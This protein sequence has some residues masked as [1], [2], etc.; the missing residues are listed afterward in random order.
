MYGGP[1]WRQVVEA[2]EPR[3]MKTWKMYSGYA[4]D[5]CAITWESHQDGEIRKVTRYRTLLN[6]ADW[7]EV[8]LGQRIVR[9]QQVP[10]E[11]RR[12]CRALPGAEL[13]V[14]ARCIGLFAWDTL[15]APDH[16]ACAAHR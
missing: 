13:R 3:L 4:L 15:I 11:V 8:P 1:T 2:P 10:N 9:R 7:R 16:D 6:R 5:E 12:M 14:H